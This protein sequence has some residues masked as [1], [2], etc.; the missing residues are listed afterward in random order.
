MIHHFAL[1]SKTLPDELCKILE[2]VVKCVNFVKAGALNSHL[3]QNLCR[4]MDL[5]HEALFFYS[6]LRWLF[7]GNVVNRVF[8][9]RGEL[10]LFLEMQGKNYLL[11]HFNMVLWEPRLASLADIFER[12]NRLNLKLQGKERN[13]YHQ[14][15]CL[16]GFFAKLR[17]GKGK[18]VPGMLPCLK[19]FQ[20]SLTKTKK[21]VCLTHYFKLKSLSI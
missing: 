14:M 8:E 5:E 4:N 20:L 18:S 10:K 17:I 9:L 7:K 16:R 6:K 2:A 1:A 11:S 19:T 21:T 15:A 12:L 13:G 3:F